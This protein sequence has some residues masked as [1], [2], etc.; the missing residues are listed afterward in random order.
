MRERRIFRQAALVALVH[1]CLQPSALTRHTAPPPVAK[2]M[3]H[4]GAG[5][6]TD[7]PQGG[8]LVMM[9]WGAMGNSSAGASAFGAR[10]YLTGVELVW[11]SA[12]AL[13]PQY[14]HAALLFGGRGSNGA[15]Q[16][17]TWLVPM[18]QDARS[19]LLT[20]SNATQIETLGEQAPARWGHSAVW[21][22]RG[23]D[24]PETW[25]S[26]RSY[27][28]RIEE[29]SDLISAQGHPVQDLRHTISGKLHAISTIAPC[30]GGN[31]RHKHI[32]MDCNSHHGRAGGCSCVRLVVESQTRGVLDSDTVLNDTSASLYP[33]V[34]SGRRLEII[35][36]PG[37]GYKGFISYNSANHIYNLAPALDVQL[38][39]GGDTTH[40]VITEAEAMQAPSVP[41][42]TMWVFGGR[43]AESSLTNDVYALTTSI[44]PH[45]DG[46]TAASAVDY[47]Y[48][49]T[50][51]EDFT[52]STNGWFYEKSQLVDFGSPLRPTQGPRDPRIVQIGPAKTSVCGEYGSILGGYQLLGPDTVLSKTY[53]TS[54]VHTSVQISFDFIK[55]DFWN[56]EQVQLFVDGSLV[57]TRSFFSNPNATVREP[58]ICGRDDP[59]G[60]RG[61]TLVPVNVTV[62]HSRP[63]VSISLSLYYN[64]TS[65]G[66]SN[67]TWSVSSR[68]LDSWWGL[69]RVYVR[70]L[71][72][73]FSWRKV[74]AKHV[75]GGAPS[76][77]AHHASAQFRET[78]F[79]F[80]G[81]TA[82]VVPTLESDVLVFTNHGVLNDTKLGDLWAFNTTSE[83]W[84]ALAPSIAEQA[85]DR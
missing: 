65:N 10:E 29:N 59:P 69:R 57:W 62:P 83:T 55:I 39:F 45:L 68:S 63:N 58:Q 61:E 46:V 44:S 74:D 42:D 13:F 3:H 51:F 80:G 32:N 37:R 25:P 28:G 43:D 9:A 73:G 64:G 35:A 77:R 12:D 50:G 38:D 17:D 67:G 36:G 31:T 24:K 4:V 85:R 1:V 72:R 16:S 84:H 76:P 47:Q 2:S 30:V 54:A 56:G 20:L 26:P 6:L 41:L 19:L 78:M 21:T 14:R 15:V 75:G 71:P 22:G 23:S 8:G 81:S 66:T 52:R 7:C 53:K 49:P 79:V 34:W 60:F 48:S 40:F 70:T 33:S 82:R 27:A 11:N 5:A 18:P